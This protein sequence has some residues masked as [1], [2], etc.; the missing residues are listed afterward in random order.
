VVQAS[1]HAHGDDAG[2]I[3]EYAAQQANGHLDGDNLCNIVN[4]TLLGMGAQLE[5]ST[6]LR[7]AMFTENTRPRRKHTTT[8]RF[9]AFV[10]VCRAALDRLQ[11]EQIVDPPP[12]RCPGSYPKQWPGATTDRSGR[13]TPHN[14]VEPPSRKE[15]RW[16]RAIWFRITK[17]AAAVAGG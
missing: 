13:P 4:R 12:L 15:P 8:E 2:F 5:L 7:N 11:A 16:Y 9:W 10:K 14:D 1:G 6:A 17:D 3:A